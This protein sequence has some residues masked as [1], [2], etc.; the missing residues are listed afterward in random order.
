[1]VIVAWN[2]SG[3]PMDIFQKD[4]FEQALSIFIT[5]AILRL[6]QGKHIKQSQRVF[7]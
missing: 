7:S 3:S 1:M 5:A 4:L 6:I 2:G